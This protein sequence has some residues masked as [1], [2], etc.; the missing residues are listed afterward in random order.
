MEE[1]G[2]DLLLVCSNVSPDAI[3]D[4]ALAAAQLRELAERAAARGIRIAYE[5][6][7]WGR[8][9]DDYE[10][11]WRIVERADHPA[12]GICL[13]TFHI[14]SR[15]ADPAG[16]ATSRARRSSSSSSPTRRDL[17]MDVLQWSR[18]YRCFPGQ[19]GFDLAASSRTCSPPA[20]AARCRSRS[21][22][23]SSARPI[24]GGR[25][26]TRCARC[27][28]SR[29]S[30]RLRRALRGYAFAELAGDG[31]S[32]R[33]WTGLG[34]R[35]AGRHRTKPV[36]LWEQGEHPP[37]GQPRRRAT[38]GRRRGRERRPGALDRPRRAA[39]RAGARPRAAGR[40]R[41]T[42][43][44]SPRPTAPRCSS[45]ARRRLGRRL[46]PRGQPATAR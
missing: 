3:D 41:P 43:P 8:H 26:S 16:I 2:A 12:L 21:S 11:A 32:S 24:R 44:R 20:I 34:F 40:A 19:G 23:T 10:H 25:R 31:Q 33:C 1:L 46:H 18:H 36:Q 27:S 30:C 9:V 22:T 38:C 14:L 45:A 17:V 4:D 29:T 28:C 6:L 5:A 35:H 7:A 13:D 42:S 37:G 15:G 39:A